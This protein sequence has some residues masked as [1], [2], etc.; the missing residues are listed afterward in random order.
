MVIPSIDVP[1]ARDLVERYRQFWDESWSAHTLPEQLAKWW[2]PSIMHTPLETITSD[3]R[4]S[5][6]ELPN[7][8]ASFELTRVEGRVTAPLKLHGTVA[9]LLMRQLGRGR[10]PLP[11]RVLHLP[12]AVGRQEGVVAC[13]A[14]N[15][16]ASHREPT[17]RPGRARRCP[18]R[19]SRSPSDRPPAH[20]D[21]PRATRACCVA[22]DRRVGLETTNDV[23]QAILT[24]SIEGFDERGRA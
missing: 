16:T 15:T 13:P 11:A 7:H 19:V 3:S 18:R 22:L 14:G 1:A 5:L 2:G 12:T 10:R 21:A 4:L 23:W 8:P 6:I 20:P 24:E 17:T 9:R